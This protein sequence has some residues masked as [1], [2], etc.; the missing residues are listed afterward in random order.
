MKQIANKKIQ[1][2]EK[3]MKNRLVSEANETIYE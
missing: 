1:K 3:Y 2:F